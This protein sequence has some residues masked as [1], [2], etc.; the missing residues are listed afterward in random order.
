MPEG[1]PSRHRLTAREYQLMGERGILR[2][3]ARVE[4]IDGEIIDMAPIGS[5][6]AALVERLADILRAAVRDRF[7]VRTQQPLAINEYSEP[8]PDI[9]LVRRRADYYVDAHPSARDVLLIV[10][11]AQS[12]LHYDSDIKVP[13]Y[14]RNQ[15]PEV[16]VVDVERHR[17]K[18]AVALQGDVYT[19]V[20]SLDLGAPVAIAADPLI[21]IDLRGLFPA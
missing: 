13:F 20:E 10:E 9:A 21:A 19:Q 15:I 12:S 4:L 16:W 18:R 5:R 8:E 7:M 3:D 14:A 6:H 2:A 1:L 17:I 11:V